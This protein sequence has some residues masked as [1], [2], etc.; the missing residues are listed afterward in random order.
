MPKKIFGPKFILAETRGTT[1]RNK[2]KNLVNYYLVRIYSIILSFTMLQCLVHRL[3]NII[4]HLVLFYPTNGSTKKPL[5]SYLHY[6]IL[7][8]NKHY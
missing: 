2:C 1:E 4:V 5:F 6:S 8:N 7:L 3:T